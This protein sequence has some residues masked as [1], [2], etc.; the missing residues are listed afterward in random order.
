MRSNVRAPR[1]AERGAVEFFVFFH[2]KVKRPAPGSW[3]PQDRPASESTG[4]VSGR[5]KSHRPKAPLETR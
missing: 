3:H 4:I 2:K 5:T 1:C